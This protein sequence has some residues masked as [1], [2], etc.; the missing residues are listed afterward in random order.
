MRSFL[1]TL[2]LQLGIRIKYFLTSIFFLKP[3]FMQTLSDYPS[4]LRPEGMPEPGYV[5]RFLLRALW[6]VGSIGRG[7][8]ALLF[9]AIKLRVMHVLNLIH[10]MIMVSSSVVQ[11]IKIGLVFLAFPFPS[12]Q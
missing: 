11:H 10:S 12:K 7:F 9:I 8:P 3:I 5:Q 2:L 4:M 1:H 6:M